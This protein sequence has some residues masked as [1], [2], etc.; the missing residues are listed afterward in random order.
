MAEPLLYQGIYLSAEDT[1]SAL[2][3]ER[4]FAKPYYKD[5]SNL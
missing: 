1:D 5:V 4:L 3:L 2:L